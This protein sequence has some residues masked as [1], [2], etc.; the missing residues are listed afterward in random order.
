M[1]YNNFTKDFSTL[2]NN[3]LNDFKEKRNNNFY[4][5]FIEQQ[6]EVNE[7][8]LGNI[9]KNH[10]NKNDIQNNLFLSEKNINNPEFFNSLEKSGI[11]SSKNDEFLSLRKIPK[12]SQREFDD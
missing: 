9:L 10:L 7:T 11:F 6:N 8:I 5:P 3:E 12:I 2:F 1:A 4:N